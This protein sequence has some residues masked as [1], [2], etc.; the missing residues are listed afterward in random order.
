MWIGIRLPNITFK[1]TTMIVIKTIVTLAS[2]KFS[3]NVWYLLT[4]ISISHLRHIKIA[5]NVETAPIYASE[6]E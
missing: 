6:P 3:D 4:N 1:K 5:K 2:C